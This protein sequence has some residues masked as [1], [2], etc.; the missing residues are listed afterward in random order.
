M[1][2]ELPFPPSVNGYWRAF[3]RGSICTQIIAQKGRDYRDEVVGLLQDH[4]EPLEQRLMVKV[5]LYPPDRRRRDLDNYTKG[6]LDAIT[7]AEIWLDD[8]QIDLLIVERKEITKGG[9]AVV[10]IADYKDAAERWID[11]FTRNENG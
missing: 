7:H 3:K 8:S 6:L 11:P 1:R 5:S 9:Y 4:L 10:E 2:L